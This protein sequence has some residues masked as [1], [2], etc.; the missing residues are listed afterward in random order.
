MN[1]LKKNYPE[2]FEKLEEALNNYMTE[3]DF[4]KFENGF[5]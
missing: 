2:K 5:S 1:D 4:E 3:N